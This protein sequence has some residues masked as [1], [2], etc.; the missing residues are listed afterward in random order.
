MELRRYIV[1]D[2]QMWESVDGGVILYADHLADR[3]E[4]VREVLK[5]FEI[6]ATQW[7]HDIM[8][9]KTTC[10]DLNKAIAEAKKAGVE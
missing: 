4:L 10:N 1:R 5:P 2:G 7:S 3:A 6:L 9:D 8:I